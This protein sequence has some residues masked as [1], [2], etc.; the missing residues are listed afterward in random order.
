MK[1]V[2]TPDWFMN[3]DVLIEGFSFLVLTAFFFLCYR[4]YK[5][6]KKKN[7]LYLGFGFL[8]IALAQLSVILTKFVLY[9]DTTFTQQVGQLIIT[10][11]VVNSVDIFYYIGFFFQKFLTLAG[12]YIIYRLPKK[13]FGDVLLAGYFLI[14]SAVFSVKAE[15]VYHITVL[16]LLVMI[17]RNYYDIYIKNKSA[18]T[19]MLITAFVILALGHLTGILAEIQFFYV[20]GNLLELASYIMLLALIIKIIKIKRR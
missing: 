2:F 18:N 7:F 12:F 15:Y 11:H 20:L 3:A 4:Y 10:S 17:I 5:L 19:K 8:L 16:V 13:N 14:I 6:N 1:L 9:Y